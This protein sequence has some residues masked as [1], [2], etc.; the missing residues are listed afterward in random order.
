[1][2]SKE[3]KQA[4][5][6]AQQIKDQ[7]EIDQARIDLK[8]REDQLKKDM[9]ALDLDRRRHAHEKDAFE[10][11]QRSLGEIGLRSAGVKRVTSPLSD[12]ELGLEAFM[13]EEVEVV[14]AKSVN[15]EDNPVIL[16]SVNGTNQPIALGFRVRIKRKYIEALAHS[17]VD[18]VLQV[19]D[20]PVSGVIEGM[21]VYSNA[22]LTHT[23]ST[24]NDSEKGK[25]WLDNLL[26]QPG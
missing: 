22:A 9:G 24:Y 15:K 10:V 21:N 3:T 11:G 20:T 6:E 12:E 23:F 19:E 2:T 25:E 18:T 26:A 1:M 16:P 7:E 5:V 14:V 17:R 4:Q 13:N 8:E